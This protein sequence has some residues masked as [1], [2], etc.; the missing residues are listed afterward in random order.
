MKKFEEQLWIDK[1]KKI[2]SCIETNKVLNENFLEV[3]N[4][5]QSAIDDGI[6]MGCDEDDFKKKLKRLVND[7]SFS[8]G[9]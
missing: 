1:E 5:L 2:I 3:Y 9:K 6:L 4:V 7:L 8:I